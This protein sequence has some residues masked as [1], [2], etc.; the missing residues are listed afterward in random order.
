MGSLIIWSK[1]P[2]WLEKIELRKD[3]T[4]T[5]GHLRNPD[6]PP[7]GHWKLDGNSIVFFIEQEVYGITS[8]DTLQFNASINESQQLVLDNDFLLVRLR[9]LD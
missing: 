2:G 7:N 4:I 5:M 6:L 9:K 1:N 8:I 3:G